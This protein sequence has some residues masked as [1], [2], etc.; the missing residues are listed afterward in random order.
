[1]SLELTESRPQNDTIDSWIPNHICIPLT[2]DQPSFITSSTAS[3][4]PPLGPISSSSAPDNASSSNETGNSSS[5]HLSMSLSP[6]SSSVGTTSSDP[7]LPDNTNKSDQNLTI[8]PSYP[9]TT[10]SKNNIHKPVQKFCLSA[11]VHD[12]AKLNASHVSPLTKPSQLSPTTKTSSMPKQL[13]SIPK[14]VKPHTL[15]QAL[16]DPNW[17]DAMNVE[18]SAL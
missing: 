6:L 17:C 13:S 11:N 16:K 5:R 12:S 14:Q 8:Q 2:R 7:S 3:T 1:M 18:I 4:T 10:R 9:M 15:R